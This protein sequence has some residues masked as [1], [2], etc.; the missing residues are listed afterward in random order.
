MKYENVGKSGFVL[1]V[2]MHVPVQHVSASV[3]QILEIFQKVYRKRGIPGF[4][5][6]IRS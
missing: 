6:R 1:D 5:K 2:E 3:M 4:S